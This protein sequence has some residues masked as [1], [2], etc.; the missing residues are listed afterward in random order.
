MNRTAM[1]ALITQLIG[2]LKT[3]FKDCAKLRAHQCEH[4]CICI[5]K[6]K[7]PEHCWHWRALT[8]AVPL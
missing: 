3:Q 4:S 8:L 5:G 7:G 2:N 1:L 6:G